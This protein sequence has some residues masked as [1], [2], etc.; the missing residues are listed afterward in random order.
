M[1]LLVIDAKFEPRKNLGDGVFF[2]QLLDCG[3][4]MSSIAEDF[5]EAGTGKRGPQT[6]FRK[7]R[8][9]LVV[10]VEEPWKIL[11]EE[12]IAGQELPQNEGLKEPGG[13]GD[14]AGDAS[15]QD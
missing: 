6:L 9:T 3:V 2:E 14:L 11:I 4:D 7:G 15:A 13:M 5:V 12:A 10:A 8:K 1:L